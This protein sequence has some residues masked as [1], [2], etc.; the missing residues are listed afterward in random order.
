MGGCLYSD[1]NGRQTSLKTRFTGALLLTLT[2]SPIPS[3]L[4]GKD[5]AELD[6]HSIARPDTIQRV[7]I[8]VCSSSY[9]LAVGSAVVFQPHTINMSLW[10][11]RGAPGMLTCG[12]AAL[13][14][15][16]KRVRWLLVIKILGGESYIGGHFTSR[17]EA[18]AANASF[19]SGSSL[20]L[21]CVICL[22]H[23]L[24]QQPITPLF[25]G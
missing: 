8:C 17:F 3:I 2:T 12:W 23:I 22:F 4:Q 24:T 1:F 20:L 5:E 9:V 16:D 14:T 18:V 25:T 19:L 7:C 6:R 15:I 11:G 13:T 21:K 10:W